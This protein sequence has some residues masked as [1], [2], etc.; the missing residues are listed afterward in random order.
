ME[1]GRARTPDG[2]RLYAIGDVHGMD[3]MLAK[4]HG[5]IAI[6][7]ASRPVADHRVVHVGDYVD[8]GRASAGVIDRLARLS[9]DDPRIVCLMGN[10]DELMLGFL[11]E[12]ILCGPTWLGNGAPATLASYGIAVP[13][14]LGFDGLPA[15]SARLAEAMPA[16][17]KAFLAS[18]P[19][20]V[21]FG[22]FFF[23]HAGIRPGVALDRQSDEDLVWIRDAFL[24]SSRDHGAVIV[25]GHTP[26]REPEVRPNR[27]DIDTGAVYGGPLTVLALDGTEHRFL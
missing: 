2:I 13:E 4:A 14:R 21:G 20:S 19:R 18:L 3:D 24:A 17:H 15:L 8:R 11:S 9:A 23:C 10:H 7:L 5:K 25:H 16:D 1:L 26:V 22:D 12:P 6:D 27:I